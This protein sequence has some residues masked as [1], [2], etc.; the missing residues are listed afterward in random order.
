MI[1]SQQVNK[2]LKISASINPYLNIIEAYEGVL[3]FPYERPFRIERSADFTFDGKISGQFSLPGNHQLQ[4][5]GIY[6]AAKKIAQ[7]TQLARSSVDIGFKKSLLKGKGDLTISATDL[8]NQ[9]AIRQ[10]I[11]GDGFTALYENYFETQVIRVAF[12]YKF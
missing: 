5:S 8:F 9:F 12:R 6:Y 1:L 2:W 3:L 10:Q 7:G 4:V 11:T